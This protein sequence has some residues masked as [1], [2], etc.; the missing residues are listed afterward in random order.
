MLKFACICPH[1]PIIIP[2]IGKNED[3]KMTKN[4]IQAMKK[5]AQEISKKN[6]DTLIII[7]PHGQIYSDRMNIAYGGEFHGDFSQF[8]APSIKFDY[9]SYDNLAKKIIEASNE[10]GINVNEY[11]ENEILDHGIMV[12]MYYLGQHLAENVKIVPINY[13]M[14]STNTHFN[15]GQII[16]EIINSEQFKNKNIALVASGDLSHRLFYGAPDDMPLAGKEFDKKLIEDLKNKN[17]DEILEYD[18]YWVEAAGECGYRSIVI[19]LGVLS[20]IKYEP[21]ILSYEGPFG[22]GYLVANFEI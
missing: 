19:L 1:P 21:K 15:F 11:T 9:A 10:D 12:P 16:G 17:T 14:L 13:S 3:L 4:T 2:N 18:E 5:L 8:D 7:S 6:I 22:V 20:N